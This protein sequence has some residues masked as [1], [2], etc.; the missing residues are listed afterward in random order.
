MGSSVCRAACTLPT[1]PQFSFML[2]LCCCHNDLIMCLLR[3]GV[4]HLT[5]ASYCLPAE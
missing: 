2:Q 1:F 4:S 5:Q 3:F